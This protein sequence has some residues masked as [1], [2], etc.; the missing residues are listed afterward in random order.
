MS[1]KMM[2]KATFSELCKIMEGE[3]NDV[4]KCINS[5]FNIALLF[6]PSMMCQETAIITN[7]GEGVNILEAKKEIEKA[8]KNIYKLFKKQEYKDFSTKF[9]HA[10]M[11]QV[12]I[13]FSAYFD[14]MK[15]YLPDEEKQIR[16]SPK[17]K[18]LLTDESI[19][20]Y[21]EFLRNESTNIIDQNTKDI[22]DRDLSM[23]N[24]IEDIDEYLDRLED[25]YDILNREFMLFYEKLSFWD[26]LK[27]GKRDKFM[28]TVRGLPR[29]AVENYEKQYY[30]L[31]TIFGDFF[32][33]TNI[34]EHKSIKHRI[35][36][37]FNEI[38]NLL[39]EYIES[40]QE[41]KAV[42]TLENYRKQYEEDI[43]KAVVGTSEMET[44][45]IDNVVLPAKKDIFVPQSYRSLIYKK[46]MH[47][48]DTYI[49]SECMERDDIGKCISDTLRHPIVGSYPLLILGHPG[50]GKSLL[51]NM[52]AARILF[53]E[54]HVIII[55]LRDTIA[56]DTIQQQ[57]N[58]QIEKDFSNNCSWSDITESSLDKPILLIF[59]GYDELLQASGRTYSNYLQRINEFQRQQWDIHGMF[60]KCIIT[61]RVTLIDKASIPNN[62]P[63][64]MLSDFDENRIATWSNI[65]NEKNAEYFSNNNL[66]PFEVDKTSKVFELAKQPLLLLMLALFD[67]N[68]NALKKNK[69]LNRTQLYDSLIRDF[70]SREKRKDEGFRGKQER[71]QKKIID[72]EVKKVSIAALGMYNRKALYIRSV[73]LENDLKFILN[74]DGNYKESMNMELTESDKLL[75]SFFF[76]HRSNS[77]DLVEKEKV[78]NA[79]YEFL[80][81]T[82]GEFLT[83][84]YIVTEMYNVLSYI[85]LLLRGNMSNQWELSKNPNWII[86]LV[87]A[88]LFSRPVVVKMIHEWAQNYFTDRNME[89]ESIK[90]TLD[91][92]INLEIKNI[93][94]GKAIYP[95]KN[96]I[97]EKGNSYIE[98]DI[99][100]HLAI[101][102]LNIILLRT[103]IGGEQYRFEID[104]ITWDKLV[105]LWKFTFTSDDLLSYAN[106]IDARREKD[107]CTIVYNGQEGV[108]KT[109]Y[110]SRIEKLADVSS[111]IGDQVSYGL[112]NALIGEGQT[113]S[114]LK[115]IEEKQLKV[116][117]RF[118]W[119]R[120][121]NYLAFNKIDKEMLVYKLDSFLEHCL[122]ENDTQYIF[123]FYLLVN[124]ML[125]RNI[126]KPDRH[127]KDFFKEWIIKGLAAIDY[128][129]VSHSIGGEI[130]Y[131]IIDL[132]VE[133]LNYVEFDEEIVEHIFE[134]FLRWN[135]HRGY[136]F[137]RMYREESYFIGRFYRQIIN[138]A[139]SNGKNSKYIKKFL[140]IRYVEEYFVRVYHERIEGIRYSKK[141]ISEL[142]AVFYNLYLLE[143]YRES[144]R[145]FEIYL[146]IVDR[147][148]PKN[149]V[150]ITHEQKGCFIKY[151]YGMMGLHYLE[152]EQVVYAIRVAR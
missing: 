125:K 134:E 142:F 4:T 24:P 118:L 29:K 77:T 95:L 51:C 79:A 100:N 138:S 119:N 28:A 72:E 53:H 5:I 46:N 33:W 48:E 71:E 120:L 151:L 104:D 140:D 38:T 58:Q 130:A 26:E 35:D 34:R 123:A 19:E 13:V 82:F 97:D 80:H 30:Q 15:N 10:Q 21:I 116:S 90:E 9:E 61:S 36:I 93:V 136:R 37:G 98:G 144:R 60:V 1:S 67:S 40:R 81:N 63:V 102:S 20:K 49:W 145:L 110:Q 103:I 143:E 124:Y 76:I 117:S 78:Q 127:T 133:L 3:K 7:I 64:I 25:F 73:E 68:Q 12:M 55:K 113:D 84:N 122:E 105:C 70:I 65:W 147:E 148:A 50:A 27:E 42:K 44:N 112:V 52:L 152:R 106:I 88:P 89:E 43:K 86:C 132:T 23:P 85:D 62:T 115:V 146:E 59:D 109:Y 141:F 94:S 22:F 128:F 131:S 16:I 18:L 54:Y 101:Y 69:E 74:K 121:L 99:L 8:I 75:G 56:D 92:Y 91:F 139:L 39:K 32:V 41:T 87:Y 57:I 66:Q 149:K 11:V 111:A 129:R 137:E 135:H 45:S 150:Q 107:C 114:I 14:A 108:G 2:E 83:A 47:L 126:L 6:F 17:E 31:A 96:V